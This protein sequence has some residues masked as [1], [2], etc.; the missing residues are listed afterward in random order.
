MAALDKGT[1]MH[2][3]VRIIR[4]HGHGQDLAGKEFPLVHGVRM[5]SR[6]P[7]IMVNGQNMVGFP[8]R[9]FKIWFNH[10]NDLE[11]SHNEN[12]PMLAGP[13]APF[14]LTV[15]PAVIS[16]AVPPE[17]VVEETDQQVKDR[18]NARFSVLS[19]LAGT[20]ARGHNKGLL[21][22][23]AP[24]LG[25]SYEVIQTMDGLNVYNKLQFHM[26]MQNAKDKKKDEDA[27]IVMSGGSQHMKKIIA[28]I[29]NKEQNAQFEENSQEDHSS[30]SEVNS[31]TGSV[32]Q[33]VV[34]YHVVKGTMNAAGLYA[35][36]YNNRKPNEILVVDDC[37]SVTEDKVSLSLLKA[38]LDTSDQ[39]MIDWGATRRADNLPLRFEYQ[40]GIIFISNIDFRY[41]S[42]AKSIAS[43]VEAIVDRCLYLDMN[44]RN[45]RE[46][47]M[48]IRYV[49]DDLGG[50]HKQRGLKPE[51]VQEVLSWVEQHA[52]KI[53]PLSIRSVM[54]VGSLY[55][56]SNWQQLA[57]ETL[58]L[59]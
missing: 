51:E 10:E 14:R 57:S 4:G 27:A 59:R 3:F 29:R 28:E 21:V 19:E 20:V 41:G 18:V 25:K 24:G 30:Y 56:S 49:C 36:L 6:G 32:E 58:L 8:Q 35:T 17:A 53:S 16:S 11:F 38:A 43:H 33:K 1:A 47:L 5:G 26:M 23:G 52:E 40:G 12:F 50:L 45:T 37:D 34:T 31:I 46:K 7:F 13:K 22:S 2:N 55:R 48:R 42:F 44:I 39:R 9:N 15:G 54:H